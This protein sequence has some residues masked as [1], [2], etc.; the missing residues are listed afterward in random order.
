MFHSGFIH[1]LT[2]LPLDKMA[3]TLADDNFKCIFLNGND[4]ILIWISLK[5]VPMSP[6]GNK[7]ALVQVMAKQVT[8]HY[9]N[10]CAPSSLTHLYVSLGGDELTH[11]VPSQNGCCFVDDIFKCIFVNENVC[12]SFQISLK[13][14]PDGPV[15]CYLVSLVQV[16]AWCQTGDQWWFSLLTHI[17]TILPPQVNDYVPSNL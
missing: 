6:I 10:Q 4:G 9:L 12:I 5:F 2:H 11:Q 3:A 14:V 17:C 8:S 15:D 16:M 7:P 1:C 13:F